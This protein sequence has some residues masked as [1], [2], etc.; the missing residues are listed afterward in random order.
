MEPPTSALSGPSPQRPSHGHTNGNA[1]S[2][3]NDPERFLLLLRHLL[4]SHDPRVH[5]DYAEA[6]HRLGVK[7]KWLRER[8]GDL[9]HRKMG[10]FVLFSK[11]DLQTISEMFAVRPATAARTAPTGSPAELRPA[12]SMRRNA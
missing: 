5:V 8:I 12:R 6:A 10:K 3:G 1:N 7:E 4:D 2:G 11:Q 9:P